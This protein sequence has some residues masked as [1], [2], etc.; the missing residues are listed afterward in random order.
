MRRRVFE[1]VWIPRIKVVNLS[2]PRTVHWVVG[3][4]VT[5]AEYKKVLHIPRNFS[6]LSILGQD[7]TTAEEMSH[8]MVY[9]TLGA[10]CSRLGSILPL[11]VIF[12]GWSILKGLGSSTSS[13][14]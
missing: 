3:N 12:P 7:G 2:S 9:I 4:G 14:L 13:H 8:L 11:V 1:Q 5:I 10:C 6:K